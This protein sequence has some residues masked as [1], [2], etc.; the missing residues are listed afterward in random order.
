MKKIDWH[1]DSLLPSTLIDKD[2]KNTQNVR[3]LFK[4]QIG[5]HF[6]FDRSFMQYLKENEGVSLSNAVKEW[7]KR[8]Q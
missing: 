5:D 6:H 2:Y 1:K 8:K 7:K 3:R 4:A